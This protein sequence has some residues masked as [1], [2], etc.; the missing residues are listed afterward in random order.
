MNGTSMGGCGRGRRRWRR[1]WPTMS[2]RCVSGSRRLPFNALETR[3]DV[4]TGDYEIDEDDYAAD[5]RS[6]GPPAIG[7]GL[8]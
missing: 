2:G 6:T 3:P 4:G 1:A 7:R 8:A 5:S